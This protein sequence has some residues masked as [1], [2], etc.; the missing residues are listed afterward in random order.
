MWVLYQLRFRRT[1]KKTEPLIW[2]PPGTQAASN[3]VNCSPP[4]FG[5]G[6]SNYRSIEKKPI[7]Q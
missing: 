6:M 7:V 1:T 3:F 2:K 4:F 5:G